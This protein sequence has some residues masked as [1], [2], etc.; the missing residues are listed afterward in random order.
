L[1][2]TSAFSGYFLSKNIKDSK[3]KNCANKKHIAKRPKIINITPFHD[4]PVRKVRAMVI[5]PRA[6]AIWTPI[7]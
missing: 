1:K 6:Q 5:Y 7:E 2:A 4:I 3:R